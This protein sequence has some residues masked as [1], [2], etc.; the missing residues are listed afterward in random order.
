MK[1]KLAYRKL[2]NLRRCSTGL[3]SLLRL[4]LPNGFRSSISNVSHHG[5]VYT[6]LVALFGN[7]NHCLSF[8]EGHNGVVHFL[9]PQ[10]LWVLLCDAVSLRRLLIARFLLQS[11][12]FSRKPQNSSFNDGIRM[13]GHILAEAE[14]AMSI[15]PQDMHASSINLCGLSSESLIKLHDYY[16]QL[17]YIGTPQHCQ[18]MQVIQAREYLNSSFIEGKF[19]A[20]L[21]SHEWFMAI[22]HFYYLDSFIKG[23]ALGMIPIKYVVFPRLGDHQVFNKVA[24]QRYMQIAQE[25]G[26]LLI[27]GQTT[28]ELPRQNI[29]Y[30]PD[31][32]GSLVMH[33]NFSFQIQEAWF[34]SGRSPFQLLG[35][36]EVDACSSKLRQAVGR[37]FDQFITLH[38]RQPGYRN[39][40]GTPIAFRNSN[41]LPF[42]SAVSSALHSNE[43]CIVL[44]DGRD[45]AIP[46]RFNN[47]LFDYPHSPLKSEIFDLY[48]VCYS[49]LHIGTMS[50]LSLIPNI[51]RA[52]TLCLDAYVFCNFYGTIMVP[53]IL[54]QNDETVAYPYFRMK[55]PWI[56]FTYNEVMHALSLQIPNLD[57]DIIYKSIHSFIKSARACSFSRQELVDENSV[58]VVLPS[59]FAE[60][61]TCAI[62]KSFYDLHRPLF[63][64]QEAVQFVE[65][66]APL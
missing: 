66:R 23:I 40:A 28:R 29:F 3:K 12:S 58:S 20:V 56:N 27:D 45:P 2:V 51:F 7:R 63:S 62:E 24:L 38:V 37:S 22:G 8:L 10:A 64:D 54:R 6:I 39:D 60:S 35:S 41:P 34:K 53:R 61:V 49:I 46:S 50:G 44:G 19:D 36:H 5:L 21:L 47:C 59:P 13:V 26:I 30:W 32:R 11:L 42:Y 65:A 16:F 57:E 55:W 4:V 52:T 33:D 31:N 43:I 1:L 18:I 17:N 9:P 15:N 25:L 48:L 14:Q